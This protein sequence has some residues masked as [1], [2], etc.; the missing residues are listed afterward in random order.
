MKVKLIAALGNPGKK[1]ES[2]RHNVGFMILDHLAEQ[3]SASFIVE[4]KWS[5]ATAAFDLGE[6]RVILAKPQTFM[7]NSGEA[8]S[9][10]KNF[11]KIANA[12]ILVVHDEIDLPLGKI[13]M[14]FD[15]SDA[16]H[17]GVKSIIEQIG[18]DFHRL[19]IGVDGRQSRLDMDTHDYVLQNFTTEE[20]DALKTKI[21]P[22]A[23]G[24]IKKFIGY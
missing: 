6:T 8:I 24:E 11:F 3:F 10:V 9:A 1:Y 16:G 2:T 21:L 13:R 18:Q 23:Q 22:E 12:D 17:N 5:V 20:E 15:A 19:R 14:S 4:Q 7:N